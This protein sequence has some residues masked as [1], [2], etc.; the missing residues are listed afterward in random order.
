MEDKIFNPNVTHF[1]R[2]T[3]EMAK[4]YERKNHDYGDSFSQSVAEHGAIAG[5]VRIGDKYN[6]AKQLLVA[7]EQ[8]QVNTE[9]AVDTLLDLA[10]YAI[11]LAM[12][13]QNKKA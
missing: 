10:N 6:R 13:I 8:P 4:T 12:E 7:N 9:S 2:I 3:E 1:K 11:M 5:I